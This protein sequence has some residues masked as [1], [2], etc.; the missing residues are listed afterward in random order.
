[1]LR[2]MK[3]VESQV[4]FPLPLLFLPRADETLCLPGETLHSLS[5][6]FL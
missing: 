5:E 4:S 3:V 1:M 6:V 2:T